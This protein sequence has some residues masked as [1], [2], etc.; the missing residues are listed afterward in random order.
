MAGR[1]T[2]FAGSG[3]IGPKPL[4]EVTPGRSMLDI[5]VD[6][7]RLAEEHRIIV[8]CLAEHADDARLQRVLKRLGSGHRLV[9]ADEVTNG[10]AATTL[11]AQA[12]VDESEELIVAYS[13]GTLDVDM[14][15][16]VTRFRAANAD[17]GVFSYPSVGRMDAYATFEGNMVTHIAEKRVISPDAIAGT[18]YFRRA[19]DFFS[20]AKNLLGTRQGDAEIFVSSAYNELISRDMRIVVER[21]GREQRIEMGTPADLDATR[22][23]LAGKPAVIGASGW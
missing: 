4:I 23:R 15:E 11:L 5:V 18:Y 7:F 17:G 22:D 14:Q 8:V 9:V 13:D 1:G 20:A 21:I 3:E 2:R 19:G 12:V 6:R 16:T 10:P